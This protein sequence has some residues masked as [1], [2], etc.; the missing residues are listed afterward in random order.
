MNSRS[1]SPP[2]TYFR[3]QRSLSPFSA[4]IAA[5]IST[6]SPAIVP[7]SRGRHSTSRM[8]FSTRAAKAGGPETTRARVSAMCSQVQ[9]SFSW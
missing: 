9:A 8:T 5:R 3:F 6:T 4:A 2:A 1:T 7:A